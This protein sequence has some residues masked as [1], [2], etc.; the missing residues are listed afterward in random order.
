MKLIKKVTASSL[1]NRSS[2]CT[3]NT[4]TKHWPR[5]NLTI[6]ALLALSKHCNTGNIP[7]ILKSEAFPLVH[8]SYYIESRGFVRK[9]F[10]CCFTDSECF[11]LHLEAFALL[12]PI[13]KHELTVFS[14][15]I[16]RV[17][18]GCN[19]QIFCL[20]GSIWNRTS[21]L[22]RSSQ[23]KNRGYRNFFPCL[24][25]IYMCWHKENIF[26]VSG[27]NLRPWLGS[28]GKYEVKLFKAILVVWMYELLKHW[29]S[30]VSDYSG[31]SWWTKYF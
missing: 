28:H 24:P 15:K 1:H 10:L 16:R 23:V 5:T 12:P 29:I 27:W 7:L 13:L 8:I 4:K 14:K 18:I 17:L 31:S 3:L 22:G 30:D 21:Y 6:T 25:L 9:S 20:V 11:L 2:T 19:G 26:A